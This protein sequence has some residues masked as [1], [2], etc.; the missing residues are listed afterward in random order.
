MYSSM[1]LAYIHVKL[2]TCLHYSIY[3]DIPKVS[4]DQSNVFSFY[5]SNLAHIADQCLL[6]AYIILKVVHY[7]V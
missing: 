7:N 4:G 2:F 5:Q 3:T 1:D 6:A